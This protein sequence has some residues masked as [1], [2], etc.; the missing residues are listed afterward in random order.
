MVSVIPDF[1]TYNSH[2][3]K[4]PHTFWHIVKSRF[5]HKK[6]T[7]KVPKKLQKAPKIYFRTAAV[8][9]EVYYPH[10]YYILKK[11]RKNEKLDPRIIIHIKSHVFPPIMISNTSMMMCWNT[12]LI[13]STRNNFLIKLLSK[14]QPDVSMPV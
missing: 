2:T 10:D 13:Q 7:K 9:A 14:V 1:G 3:N 5:F 4:S 11:A 12:Y 8:W 6:A